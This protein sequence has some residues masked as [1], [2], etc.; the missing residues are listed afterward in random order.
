[1]NK[2]TKSILLLLGA[3]MLCV[4]SVVSQTLLKPVLQFTAACNGGQ[5][6]FGVQ[7]RYSETAFNSD[8][9]FTIELSDADGNW[10]NPTNV[11]TITEEN[12]TF[13]FTK[14]FQL[15]DNTYGTNYRIRLVATSPAMTSP[16]SD[17]FEAYKYPTSTLILN[18]FENVYL[19][20][21]G[22]TELTL[23]TTQNGAYQWYRDDVLITTTAEPK[24]IV[25]ETG[26]YQVKID[27]GSCG[28]KDSTLVDVVIL[29]EGDSQIK[30]NSTIEI[31]GDESHTFEANVS[32]PN[33]T[34]NWYLDDTL[35]KSSNDPTYT[36]PTTGQFGTY[37][38]VIDTGECTTTSNNVVLQ[39]QT[40][41]GFEVTTQGALTRA[42]LTGEAIELC[43][44]HDASSGSIQW[45]KD[46]APLAARTQPCMNATEPGVYYA[47]VTESTGSA[48]DAVVDSEKYTLLGIKSFN[49]TIRTDTAYEACNAA[50]TNLS[51]VGVTAIAE[52]D[53]E[54]DLTASQIEALNY[55]W[56]KDGN[57]IS[58]ETNEELA[59]NSYLD[60]GLYTL[61]VSVFGAEGVS[62]ELEI[63]LVEVPEVTSSSNSNSLCAGSSIT[64]T[65][66]NVIAGYTYQWIKDG[67]EDVTPA[68]PQVLEV[69]A[70]GTYV[71]NY[72][73]YGC[74]N[75]LNPI[76]VVPFDDSAVTI[77]P[78]EIVVLESGSSATIVASGGEAYQWYQGEDTS[79]VL[80]STTEELTVTALGFYTVFVQVGNCSVIRTIEVVE[81]DG[82]IIVPNIVSPNQDGANDTWKLSNT[83]AYQPNVEVILYNSNGREI[84]KT[85][86][87]KN[88]WPM[89][90]LGNQKI[91]YYKIIKDEKLIKAGT[92]SVID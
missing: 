48:C 68:D 18:N 26:K 53:N 17:P 15:P 63:Q 5:T 92:I 44:S 8:N 27:Y 67:T 36:T 57:P 71:L 56:N 29:D 88:D 30:G 43:I 1:M 77:T 22:S 87:Y 12:D 49:A 19:C 54:Y 81:P 4:T 46:D 70:A 25:S 58:G 72:A 65:I 34:Y 78:S 50:N 86:D 45:Y 60:S 28:S 74:D 79:G 41:A 24:L 39:Q 91:F 47:R 13:T 40:T 7:F 6:D 14:S 62:N 3:L 55:Q 16:D 85:T 33:L 52:D 59:L 73:G 76:V 9:V 21:S 90:S 80:L 11:R 31:C 84:L 51:I 42:I 38:L 37:R 83:Y 61:R 82:Q 64:Y 75:E 32:Y 35:V 23:N 20:G 89:E 69:T 10:D 66:N 2:Y